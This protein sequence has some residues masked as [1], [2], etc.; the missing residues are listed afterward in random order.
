MGN[1]GGLSQPSFLV[2]GTAKDSTD[3][4]FDFNDLGSECQANNRLSLTSVSLRERFA[5]VLEEPGVAVWKLVGFVKSALR[6]AP[7]I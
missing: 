6:S 1:D 5:V 2:L 7:L 3:S 4:S